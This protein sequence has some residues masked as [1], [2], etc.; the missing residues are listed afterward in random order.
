[1]GAEAPAP[2]S[3]KRSSGG[4]DLVQQRSG[5][6]L[7]DLLRERELGGEDLTRLGEHAL[8]ARGEPPVLITTPQVADDLTHLDDVAGGELL[9]VGLVPARPVGRLL[10]KRGSQHLEHAVEALPAD[11]VAHADEVD[12]LSRDLDDEVSLRDVQLQILL[13]LALDHPVFDLD[14]RRG[15]VV[16]IDDGLANLK[17]HKVVSFR[18]SPGYHIEHALRFAEHFPEAAHAAPSTIDLPWSRAVA[19]E[20]LE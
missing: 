10:G 14:D 12:V 9:E 5:L 17:K 16:G 13:C 18:Q 20:A 15:A 11:H 4:Q 3:Q 1:A 7:V 19:A 6:L 2:P 8:L